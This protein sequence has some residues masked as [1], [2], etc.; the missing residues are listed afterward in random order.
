MLNWAPRREDVGYTLVLYGSVCSA[1]LPSR[2]TPGEGTSD[3]H[4]MGGWVGPRAGLD[5]VTKRETLSPCRELNPN[6]PIVQ[7][8]VSRYTGWAVSGRAY[9]HYQI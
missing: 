3:T 9:S 7:P 8:V 4:K 2:F 1:S 5:A 6:H